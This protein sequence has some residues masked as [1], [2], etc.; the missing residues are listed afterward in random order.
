M[1]DLRA[2]LAAERKTRQVVHPLA[3]YDKSGALLCTAC[4]LKIPAEKLW[5][6]HL[7]SANH[8]KNALAQQDGRSVSKKRKIGSD[9]DDEVSTASPAPSVAVEEARRV[10]KRT[11]S[12][13]F[14]VDDIPPTDNAVETETPDPEPNGGEGIEETVVGQ[15]SDTP[16]GANDLPAISDAPLVLLEPDPVDE[17]EWAAFE[18]DLATVTNAQS[19]TSINQEDRYAAATISAPAVSATEL[20]QRQKRGGQTQT[21][22]ENTTKTKRRDY[23][24]E[25]QDDREEEQARIADEFA[26]MEQMEDKVR[27]LREM[28]ESLRRQPV[29][30]QTGEEEKVVNVENGVLPAL[31]N[32]Q[33]HDREGDP[34]VVDAEEL[35]KKDAPASED[36]DES[37]EVD[38]WYS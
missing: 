11:K 3:A 15:Q 14:A 30:T 6:P 24:A 26:V 13:R 12:V 29:V 4:D 20:A 34:T 21:E 28:R 7:R 22:P 17:D 31:V 32:A 37:D 16:H 2:L 36:D 25:A 38:D 23:E 18:R 27:R 5:D 35:A 1:A 19:Q 8:R 10:G 33:N 9:D